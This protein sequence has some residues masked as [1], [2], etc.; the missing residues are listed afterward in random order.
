MNTGKK[1][2]VGIIEFF[3][4]VFCCLILI[5]H[6]DFFF[7][8]KSLFLCDGI[9]FGR[10]G[11]IG[12]EFFFIVSGYLMA[13][14]VLKPET[15]ESIG[16]ESLVF[17]KRK[18]M[19]ILPAHLTAFAITYI[20]VCVVRKY[21]MLRSAKYLF[22]ALPTL[23]F[24]NKVGIPCEKMIS[25]EWYVS[26]MLI[27]MAVIFPAARKYGD[28][29]LKITAPT[30][31]ILLTGYIAHKYG[32]FE[33]AEKYDL[34]TY[35]CVLRAAAEIMIGMSAYTAAEYLKKKE[36]SKG[37]R[38]ICTV[39]EI[40]CYLGVICYV[41]S[42]LDASYDFSM[43]FAVAA[44][45][46]ISFSG[47]SYTAQLFN[48]EAVYFLG[49]IS[50]PVYVIQNVFRNIIEYPLNDASLMIKGPVYIFGSIVLGI[51]V[52]FISKPVGRYLN[53]PAAE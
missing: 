4:F 17:L 32:T 15:G 30:L 23:F 27:A 7:G 48:N 46:T 24:L 50:F 36:L 3:R 42:D 40:C 14:S 10:H 12:V 28:T 1:K 39:M 9:T 20:V 2:R 53:R 44:A 49:R 37:K 29:F 26:A 6:V 45:V 18:I 31:G 47:A 8:E 5:Y 33:G 11:Y 51:I 34:F 43:M 19:A 25:V 38:T 22:D 16:T 21:S 41:F 35:M 52:Y 13:R